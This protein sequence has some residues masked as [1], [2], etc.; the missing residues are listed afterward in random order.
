MPHSSDF[1]WTERKHE[2]HRCE[3]G[4]RRGGGLWA[5]GQLLLPLALR[6][7]APLEGALRMPVA[8]RETTVS[9]FP[10]PGPPR[11][12]PGP[13]GA[14]SGTGCPASEPAPPPPVEPRAAEPC[15]SLVSRRRPPPIR[16]QRRA[17]PRGVR[18]AAPGRPQPQA[19]R[20]RVTVSEPRPRAR[21]TACR[22]FAAPVRSA[23][24]SP[25]SRSGGAC[26]P[27]SDGS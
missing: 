9:V 12:E 27:S 8:T 14:S 21:M 2:H 18:A 26:R 1:G 15:L 11:V 25:R 23:S 16:P 19:A 7:P 24:R 10:A 17:A 4:G 20:R 5:R 6:E 3:N 22:R 13:C